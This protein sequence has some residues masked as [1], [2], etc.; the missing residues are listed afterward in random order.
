VRPGSIRIFSGRFR[1]LHISRTN[2]SRLTTV[3]KHPSVA[4]H[5]Q[6]NR[7]SFASSGDAVVVQ[8][9]RYTAGAP[10]RQSY[11]ERAG[12]SGRLIRRRKPARAQPVQC[13]CGGY[14]PTVRRQSRH[15]RLRPLAKCI[16][17]KIMLPPIGRQI[18]GQRLLIKLSVITLSFSVPFRQP[19]HS[20]GFAS[21]NKQQKN[22]YPRPGSTRRNSA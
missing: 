2:G 5:H 7:R 22:V 4:K 15:L 6:K 14:R 8:K 18:H 17:L 16:Q 13:R 19:T 9:S 21:H 20:N 11:L 12:D 3:D 1:G 10:P